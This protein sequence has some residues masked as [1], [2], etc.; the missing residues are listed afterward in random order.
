VS[1]VV[2]QTP[3]R[4]FLDEAR[5]M[6]YD[7][8]ASGGPRNASPAISVVVPAYN[9]A[10]LTADTID[11]LLAQQFAPKA[12]EIIVIDNGSTDAGVMTAVLREK[13]KKARVLFV[14]ARIDENRGPAVA[15]N[16]GVVLSSGELIAF[17]DN[18]C[19]P[20]PGW[21]RALA[22]GM[23]DGAGVAQGRTTADPKQPQPLFNHFIETNELDG[24][25]STSNACY[26]REALKQAGGFD[27]NCEYWEDVDLGWRVRRLG[28]EAVFVSEALVHH[29]VIRVSPVDWLMQARRF[30]NWP[31]KAA[32][33][34]EFRRH[35]FLRLWSDPWHP[36]FQAFVAGIALSPWRREA[37]LLAIPYLATFPLRGRLVG[38]QPLLRAAATIAR[39]AVILSSLV[40]GSIR[41]KSPVL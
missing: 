11:A 3:P 24:S 13:A 6:T 28:W 12:Y 36:L 14:G 40:G 4:P 37:L 33:Y 20:T 32:R 17:T 18:D 30:G 2:K 9:R 34:P 16:L 8:V 38:R 23:P 27:P 19:V 21:L 5:G 29:Q 41:Y 1:T 7:I 15:R 22:V 39:D 31:A 25:F 35:L 26:R 10:D